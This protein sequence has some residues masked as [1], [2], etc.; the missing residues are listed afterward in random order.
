[1]QTSR[2]YVEEG[3]VEMAQIQTTQRNPVLLAEWEK[4]IGTHVNAAR[5][6]VSPSMFGA[7]A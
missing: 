1:V 6:C 5:A 2:I 7:L 3:G 4:H